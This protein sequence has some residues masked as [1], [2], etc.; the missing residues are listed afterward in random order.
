MLL[1]ASAGASPQVVDDV[2]PEASTSAQAEP[3]EPVAGPS[4]DYD[5][6]GDQ[7]EAVEE[8]E[9]GPVGTT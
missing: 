9:E 8:A 4:H 5:G 1:E 3:A 6:E 7:V 2:E